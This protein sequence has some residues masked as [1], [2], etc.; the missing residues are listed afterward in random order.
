LGVFVLAAAAVQPSWASHA[1]EAL[2]A[3]QQ[4]VAAADQLLGALRQYERLPESQRASML[5]RMTQLAAQRR[6]RM[7]ALLEQDPSLAA[8]RVLP[9]AVRK[10][11]PSQVQAQLEREVGIAGTVQATIEEDLAGR[12]SRTRF[13]LVDTVGRAFG[14]G[15][16]GASEHD[17]LAMVDKRGSING[18]QIGRKLLVLDKRNVQ[19]AAADGTTTTASTGTTSATA[20]PIEGDQTTLVVLLDFTDVAVECTASDLQSRLFGTTGATMNLGFQ[21]SSGGKVSFSGRVI[22]PFP[23]SYA[24][25]N[26][27]DKDGWAAQANAA[28]IAAGFNPASYKRVSYVTPRN[29]TCGWTGVATIGG[30]L[31]TKSWIQQCTRTGL[32]S[33]EIGHNLRFHHAATPTYDYGDLTDPMGGTT[34]VQSNA[35]NR[36]MAGWL[37][38]SQVQDVAVGGSYA[39]TALENAGAT[40]P[41]V[42]RLTKPDTAES[43]YVSLRQ[44]DGIDAALPTGSQ[45]TLSIHRATGTLPTRTYLVGS[46]AAGQSWNDSV[47]GIQVTNGGV[48]GTNAVVGVSFSGATCVRQAPTVTA[49]PTSQ[50]AASG[51]TLGYSVNVKNNNSTACPSVTFGLT[52]ALPAGFSGSFAAASISLASGAG[53]NMDWNVASPGGIA[54]AT[55]TLTATATDAATG[56][57]GQAHASYVVSTPASAST[58]TPTDTTPPTVSIVTPSSGAVISSRSKTVTISANASDNVGVASVQFLVDGQVVASL[59]SPPYSAAWGV[60]RS[61]RGVRVVKVR[62]LDAAGN[63]AE[64]SLAVTVK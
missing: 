25:A 47:N 13:E 30:T 58:P 31:P 12:H 63:A 3:D 55:Y 32:F 2:H 1:G 34:L 6:E 24:S 46:V 10:R 11:M 9:Q 35:A 49:T 19:L 15:I 33:H 51:T 44:A 50:A 61:S 4:A 36:V 23:I 56:N 8:L 28:A 43:Y 22:G 62:A 41:Q 26:T 39:L 40:S 18:L 29:A 5:Q 54:D 20:S 17:M 57:G 38:G 42:L 59:T 14:L 48:S 60:N 7:I 53:A 21:Q 27:C 52:Q 45:N 16:A 64:Q 37:A